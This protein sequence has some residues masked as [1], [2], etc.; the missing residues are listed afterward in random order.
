MTFATGIT[1]NINSRTTSW[2]LVQDSGTS[3]GT[4]APKGN[5]PRFPL[6]SL[7]VHLSRRLDERCLVEG[8]LIPVDE[9][10]LSR[11][12]KEN[13]KR[14][15]TNSKVIRL[16][17][18]FLSSCTLLVAWSLPSR[19]GCS[20]S[21]ETTPGRNIEAIRSGKAL[22][23]TGEVCGAYAGQKTRLR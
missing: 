21:Q 18:W 13:N 5:R 9:P 6:I 17:L 4:A 11:R 23:N 19:H 16:S 10:G 12:K 15:C 2:R 7:V 20:A 1:I 22:H 3:R 8:L 14:K